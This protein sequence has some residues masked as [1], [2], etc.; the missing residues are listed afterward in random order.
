MKDITLKQLRQLY[1]EFKLSTQVV[2]PAT[3]AHSNTLWGFN[4]KPEQ[5]SLITHGRSVSE[6]GA[7][8]EWVDLSKYKIVDAISSE[9]KYTM[10]VTCTRISDAMT[11]AVQ[12]VACG[13]VSKSIALTTRNIPSCPDSISAFFGFLNSHRI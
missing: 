8:G 4:M 9:V 1:S 7:L 2:D 5:Q 12:G 3:G 6:S 11:D 13:V 10:Q